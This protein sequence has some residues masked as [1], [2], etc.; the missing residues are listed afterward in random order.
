MHT[1]L[2]DTAAPD[3]APQMPE[4]QP[5]V[6]AVEGFTAQLGQAIEQL[7]EAVVELRTSAAPAP[8]GASAPEALLRRVQQLEAQWQ[9]QQTLADL[10]DRKSVV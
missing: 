10:E 9:L 3:A 7:V 1:L 8:E 5:R 6:E 4:W 2:P